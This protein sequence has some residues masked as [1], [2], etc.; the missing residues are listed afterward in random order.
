MK[1]V[2]VAAGRGSRL[3]GGRGVKPLTIVCGRTLLEHVLVSCRDAGLDGAVIVAG[4][5]WQ[6]LKAHALDLAGRLSFP[7]DV[8]VNPGWERGN[9]SSL[10]A[11]AGAVDGPFILT[12]SDH[13]FDPAIAALLRAD[14]MDGA[15]LLLAVDEHLHNPLVDIDDVTKVLVEDGRIVEIGKTISNWNAFDTGVFRMT[16]VVFDVLSDAAR[17]QGELGI[18][19]AVRKLA[20][21][22]RAHV[23]AI[24]E[25]F[26]ID[27]DNEAMLDL[28][29]NALAGV[30]AASA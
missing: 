2:I 29:E 16:P 9:G 12:M 15:D 24:G 26:W 3:R 18:S 27:V 22:G 20:A 14:R 1:A 11:A 10:L 19:D 25:R 21:R 30:R 13:L 5:R 8:V 4:Y 7:V 28:A 17:G 23:R 6:E